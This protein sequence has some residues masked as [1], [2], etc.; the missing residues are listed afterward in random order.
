MR[1]AC[2]SQCEL[3]RE[4]LVDECSGFALRLPPFTLFS[5]FFANINLFYFILFKKSIKG[6]KKL[7]TG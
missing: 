3:L 6:K 2:V 5:P 1:R 7:L 4:T